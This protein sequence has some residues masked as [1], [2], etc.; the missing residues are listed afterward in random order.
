MG[1]VRNFVEQ[2]KLLSVGVILYIVVFLVSNFISPWQIEGESVARFFNEEIALNGGIQKFLFYGI[3]DLL[4]VTAYADS[5]ESS[6]AGFTFGILCMVLFSFSNFICYHFF[7]KND[8]FEDEEKM[9][10]SYLYDNILAYIICIISYFVYQ[11]FDKLVVNGFNS[12]NEKIAIIIM[13]ICIAMIVVSYLQFLKIMI[14]VSGI[15]L[16]NCLIG[17]LNNFIADEL[18]FSIISFVLTLVMVILINIIVEKI[19]D[20]ILDFFDPVRSS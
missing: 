14:Y 12:G 2:H 3:Y 18:F 11:P 4:E 7:K 9:V 5:T 13:I 1:R 6:D 19:T 17:F 10:I 8:N 15:E 16:I 20:K